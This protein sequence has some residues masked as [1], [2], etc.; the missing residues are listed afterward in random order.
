V[1]AFGAL[2]ATDEA[3]R[4]LDRSIANRLFSALML[5]VEEAYDTLRAD[6]RFATCL[7][8]VGLVSVASG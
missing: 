6:P 1:G 2:G 7:R 8:A 3:F 4:W 5:G